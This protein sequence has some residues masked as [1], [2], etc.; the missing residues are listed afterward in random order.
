MW[1]VIMLCCSI[2][3]T[4][5]QIILRKYGLCWT[6]YFWYCLGCCG[7]L[8]WLMPI[9]YSKAPSFFLAYFIAIACLSILGWAAS[10]FYFKETITSLQI[11]GILII[12]VGSALLA[13]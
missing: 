13:R 12:L 4:T 11:V 1:F 7:L 9:G 8:G 2:V 3:L 10:V 6:S 5:L